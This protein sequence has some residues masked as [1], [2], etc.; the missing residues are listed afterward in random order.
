MCVCIQAVCAYNAV[1]VYN[2]VYTMLRIQCCVYNAVHVY[3]VYT[4]A[5]TPIH[6]H[7]TGLCRFS[8]SGTEVGPHRL[9]R[10]IILS[11]ETL[12]MMPREVCVC[13]E[14]V[15]LVPTRMCI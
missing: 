13:G 11:Q 12:P 7:M 15:I 14:N 10:C 4:Y 6:A 9:A 2:A 8:L 3:L 1:C 5:Q